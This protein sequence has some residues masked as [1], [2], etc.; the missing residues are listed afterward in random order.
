MVTW[1][2]VVLIAAGVAAGAV[3]AIRFLKDRRARQ[4]DSNEHD[5]AVALWEFSRTIKARMAEI[6]SGKAAVLDFATIS[7]P[8]GPGYKL[9]LELT[10]AGFSIWAVPRR[11]GKT[12]KLSFYVGNTVSVRALDRGGDRAEP[13]DPEYA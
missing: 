8:R 1:L 6:K 10:F 7:M 12:G 11:Y 3:F 13:E 9:S 4:I 2:L 5:T